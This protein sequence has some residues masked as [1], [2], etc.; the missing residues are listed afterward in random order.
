MSLAALQN[1]FRHW[2]VDGADTSAEQIGHAAGP[3]LK[4]YQN[5]YRTQLIAC[6]TDIHEHTRSWLGDDA[7]L[8]AA[9]THIDAA[10]PH[11]WTLDDYPAGFAD[12]VASLY[13]DDVEVAELVRLEW[14]L[15]RAFVAAD[16]DPV[17]PAALA[18][19]D[20][21]DA[22]IRFVPSLKTIRVNT[23]AAA[24]WSALA[25]GDIPPPALRLPEPAALLVWRQD[26]TPC[27]R[28]I[29]GVEDQAITLCA[30]G[31]SFGTLCA[32][33]VTALGE[34]DG[35]GRAAALLSQW[36]GDRIII[37]V[38]SALGRAQDA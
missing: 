13:P 11:A 3:G 1:D 5:N 33:M 2:L 17:A 8:A 9:I 34:A 36:I 21:D 20:W 25:A 23:N 4:V 27:F 19:I 16:A 12:T 15:S 30:H 7:F 28:T 32:T 26:F 10:P 24:I 35:I 31:H 22:V 37:G 18:N 14:A 38:D 29:D 6:L